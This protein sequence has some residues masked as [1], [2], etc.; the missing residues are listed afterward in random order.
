MITKIYAS[1]T[2]L[3][4]MILVHS[5]AAPGSHG[6]YEQGGPSQDPASPG[7]VSLSSSDL[8]SQSDEWTR[9][10]PEAEE[11]EATATEAGAGAV[12]VVVFLALDI[13]LYLKTFSLSL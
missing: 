13:I 8:G 2:K 4:L 12:A 5:L 9:L 7:I 11:P 1:F 3:G 10:E 6:G